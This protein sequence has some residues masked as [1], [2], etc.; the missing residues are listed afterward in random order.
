MVQ[1]NEYCVVWLNYLRDGVFINSCS[2]SRNNAGRPVLP[3]S[4]VFSKGFVSW[5]LSWIL[6]LSWPKAASRFTIVFLFWTLRSHGLMAA[7]HQF[8]LWCVAVID[9][10]NDD[11]VVARQWC[12]IGVLY[13][14]SELYRQWSRNSY[15][16]AKPWFSPGTEL[17]EASLVLETV[18]LACVK[19]DEVD[20]NGTSY[21][22][23]PQ[24]NHANKTSD[25]ELQH[26]S[27]G[28]LTANEQFCQGNGGWTP[29]HDENL[30][31]AVVRC[32]IS[33]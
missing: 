17:V 9:D 11:E 29:K 4:M 3:T 12:G 27:S 26:F 23:I 8:L 25:D 33:R 20:E 16:D 10:G 32:P 24:T 13:H 2:E 30:L 6:F 14:W 31:H 1:W 28:H 18:H 5:I 19:H 15:P 7:T 22:N 21:S